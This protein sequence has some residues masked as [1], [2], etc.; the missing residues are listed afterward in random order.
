[1][2]TIVDAGGQASERA[3]RIL[4]AVANPATCEELIRTGSA[5]AAAHDGELLVLSV[6]V[7]DDPG[8]VD[9]ADPPA[10][11]QRDV[12][13]RAMAV[14]EDDGNEVPARGLLRSAIS[15]AAGILE[16]AREFDVDSLL[17]GW[18]GGRSSVADAVIGNVVDE[19]SAKTDCDVL[20]ERVGDGVT[21]IDSIL[22]PIAGGI[23]SDLAVSTARDIARTTNAELT[24]GTVVG[25]GATDAERDS[26]AAMLEDATADVTDVPVETRLLEGESIADTIVVESRE[27][28]LTVVGATGKGSL[29]ELLFDSVTAQVARRAAGRILIARRASG[30]SRVGRLRRWL[31]GLLR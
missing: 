8:G 3:Y 20:V 5:L 1:M 9:E 2:K 14:A 16:T 31:S 21:P 29:E 15:P 26:Y 10:A 17:L 13:D 4:V 11:S 19:V 18:H 23:H 25:P 28:D 12:L 27:Y 22:V 30:R 7:T 24:V 6:V